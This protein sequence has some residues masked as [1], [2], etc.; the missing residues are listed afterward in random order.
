MALARSA[1][2]RRPRGG[3]RI[4]GQAARRKDAFGRAERTAPDS[5]IR[6]LGA[7]HPPELAAAGPQEHGALQYPVA[8]A[9][10]TRVVPPRPAHAVR[11]TAAYEDQAADRTTVASLSSAASTRITRERRRDRQNRTCAQRVSGL[12]FPLPLIRRI[13][14]SGAS[15]SVCAVGLLNSSFANPSS[16]R[17]AS[18]T[19]VLVQVSVGAKT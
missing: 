12:T 13:T 17:T 6:D 9:D 15:A 4:P 2:R 19:I 8:D 10:E 18:R 5:R 16:T 14:G 7:V 11:S 1:P 3:L